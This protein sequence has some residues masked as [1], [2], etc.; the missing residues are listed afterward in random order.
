[1]LGLTG[2]LA[3]VALVA[4][5]V[6]RLAALTRLGTRAAVRLETS[7][8]IPTLW[9]LAAGLLVFLLAAVLFNIHALA[10]LGVLVLAAGLALAGLGLAA[11]AL[12]VGTRLAEALDLL[13]IDSLG[14]LRLGLWSLGLA[15]GVP[16]AG[17]L[18]ALLLLASGLGAV[19]ETL[20]V[21]KVPDYP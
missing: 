14:A 9:G 15:A 12:S 1:M 5:L 6:G 20:T 17:W 11:A 10:L 18:L 21:R 7:R 16:F 2:C 8:A 19:L 13:E 3:V 4:L